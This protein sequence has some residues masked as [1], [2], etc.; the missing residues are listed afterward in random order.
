[1][2]SPSRPDDLACSI[3]SKP[4][5]PNDFIITEHGEV[6]HIGCRNRRL[7]FRSLEEVDR[8]KSALD[9]AR[10]LLQDAGYR[11]G[12]AARLGGTAAPRPLCGESA[13]LVD[14]RP[15][16]D[17]IVVEGCPC[18]GFY[19]AGSLIRARRL[20]FPA[21]SREALADAVLKFRA[22]GHEAWCTTTEGRENGPLVVRTERPDRP[23]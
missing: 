14:W 1:V 13:M 21:E 10:R 15:S 4:I 8:A 19:V 22:I 16:L 6:F 7:Q 9:Q 11:R 3:C 20:G 5:R 17:W 2:D 12:K 18:G 23:A